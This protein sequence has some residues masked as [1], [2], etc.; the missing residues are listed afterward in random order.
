MSTQTSGPGGQRAGGLTWQTQVS[1]RGCWAGGALVAAGRVEDSG[2]RCVCVSVRVSAGRQGATSRPAGPRGT[3]RDGA[4]A[5]AFGRS[6]S[7]TG[8]AS[9]FVLGSPLRFS[10]RKTEKEKENAWQ[11]VP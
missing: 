2:L 11:V 10:W 1:W 6:P 9:L 7:T 3:P 8:L 5:G 4:G